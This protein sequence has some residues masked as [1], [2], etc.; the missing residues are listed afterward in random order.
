MACLKAFKAARLLLPQYVKKINPECAALDS[1]LVFPFI[2]VDTLSQLKE[3]FPK[4]VVLT[5][6]IS[7]DLQL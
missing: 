7:P 5:N 4:Y 6:E 2:S 1:L 3:K